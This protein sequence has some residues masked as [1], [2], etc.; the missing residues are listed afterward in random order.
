MIGH[1]WILSFKL[2]VAVR[3]TLI[4]NAFLY[5]PEIV[6]YNIVQACKGSRLANEVVRNLY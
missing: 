3:L 1:F 2:A 5:L 6:L 4:I